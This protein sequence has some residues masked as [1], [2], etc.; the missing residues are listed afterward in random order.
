[1]NFGGLGDQGQSDVVLY[2]Y[3][4]QDDAKVSWFA[5]EDP[6]PL[7][8]FGKNKIWTGYPISFSYFGAQSDRLVVQNAGL[9]NSSGKQ[10][11][12]YTVT[13]DMEDHGQHHA[14]LIPQ[15]FLEPGET[16]QVK[17]DAVAEQDGGG[18]VDVSREWTFTT[19]SEVRLDRV[20][21]EK[22]DGN[23]FITLEW[24]S[25]KDPNAVVT[26]EMN[27]EKYLQKEGKSQT[28]Y[29]DLTPGLYTM[30]IDS[31]HFNE[32]K[33]YQIM[34]EAN[35]DLYFDYDSPFKVT[36][37]YEEG[38]MMDETE[39]DESESTIYS[40]YSVWEKDQSN[41]S[42]DKTWNIQ[43]N[44]SILPSQINSNYIYVVDS[45]NEKV[46]VNL[47]LENAGTEVVVT[48]PPGNYESGDYTLV[49]QPL[50]GE[51]GNVMDGGIQ[52]PFG[53]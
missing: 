44:K 39:V 51:S 6:N 22:H 24:A 19:A 47:M 18:S 48:P 28:T 40:D 21:F 32:V 23:N 15:D 25:G 46:N 13:P 2:P 52:L 3:A 38:M 20:Y 14:F 11:S 8:F 49:I 50:K 35:N 5:F 37:V 17:V 45:Q 30:N 27:G 42:S 33:S 4:G 26:L 31:P 12:T 43:F 10:V 41:Y 16:Y 1:M 7:R 53:I 36:K 9:F 29:K 34:I